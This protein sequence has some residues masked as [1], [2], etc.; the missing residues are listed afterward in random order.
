MWNLLESLQSL[1]QGE[2]ATILGSR[3]KRRLNAAVCSGNVCWGSVKSGGVQAFLDLFAPAAMAPPPPA[4]MKV[5]SFN[6]TTDSQSKL[7]R[8]FGPHEVTPKKLKSPPWFPRKSLRRLRL[9]N[10]Q[11]QR[12]LVSRRLFLKRH[13]MSVSSHRHPHRNARR[14]QKSRSL[15]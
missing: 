15:L 1:P 7:P 3:P 14:P 11:S 5:I 13:R 4:G 6:G 12:R 10:S 2:W 8:H 9:L